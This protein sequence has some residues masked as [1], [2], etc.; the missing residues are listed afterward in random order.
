MITPACGFWGGYL[1]WSWAWSSE[2]GLS[3]RE[4]VV[5]GVSTTNE[6][7]RGLSLSW[8]RNYVRSRGAI[9]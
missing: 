4:Y 1:I 5:S 2:I 8:S 9:E 3:R 6:G 7:R